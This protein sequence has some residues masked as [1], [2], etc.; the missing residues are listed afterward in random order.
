MRDELS[1]D[2]IHLGE[3]LKKHQDC[4]SLRLSY[5][6]KSEEKTKLAS[7]ISTQNTKLAELKAD[8]SILTNEKQQLQ[9]SVAHYE[10]TREQLGQWN[11]KLTLHQELDNNSRALLQN[12]SKKIT[13]QK[14]LEEMA[15][16]QLQVYEDTSKRV[17][18]LKDANVELEII[19]Q[20]ILQSENTINDCKSLATLL[21]NWNSSN[22]EF[23]AKQQSYLVSSRKSRELSDLFT[24]NNQ[25]FMDE[26]AGILAETLEEGS[27]C[28][29]CGSTHHLAYAKLTENAPT[30]ES[31][32]TMKENSDKALE[33]ANHDM[34]ETKSLQVKKDGLKEQVKVSWNIIFPTLPIETLSYT[35][36]SD[37]LH[38]HQEQ[39]DAAHKDILLKLNKANSDVEE[40]QKL[41][42]LLPALQEGV[43]TNQDNLIA[44]NIEIAQLD[45]ELTNY[46]NQ[47][48]KQWENSEEIC[49]DNLIYILEQIGTLLQTQC[50]N[51]ETT[52]NNLNNSKI[53]LKKIEEELLPANEKS[54]ELSTTLLQ[55]HT[56]EATQITTTLSSLTEQLTK[57][58]D[59]LTYENKD[60]VQV[61]IAAKNALI[62]SLKDAFEA[63][64][65]KYNTEK[66]H[67]TL[68]EGQL[69]SLK[70]TIADMPDIDIPSLD[71][72]VLEKKEEIKTTQGELQALVSQ[73]DSNTRNLQ[74][75][76]A[77]S[78][79]L[80]KVEQKFQ[81]MKSLSDTA[82]GTLTKKERIMLETFIQM[83]YFD[84]VTRRANI[85]LMKMTSGQFELKRREDV[86]SSSGK[87]GL[88][89]DVVDHYN[90]STR[91]VKTLSGGE[92]FKASL[93]LALGLADEIQSNAGGIKLDTMFVDEGFGSLDEESLQQAIKI[94]MELGDGNRLV[95]IISHV[96]ELK[97]KIDKQLIITKN[98][99]EGSSHRIIL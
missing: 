11:T 43:K 12:R 74:H 37:N 10:V 49:E 36:A 20:N 95:G 16:K 1:K 76:Q 75:I 88:D 45:N 41:A 18:E 13:E 38:V 91:S 85:R 59:T 97:E 19:K 28:P 89:L 92:S 4:E 7:S 67:Y 99:S 5:K 84:R 54:Q 15:S 73:L 25:I 31:L 78:V 48:K 72:K 64:E 34:S 66:T 55:N 47:V 30:K 32:K 79:E 96:N 62:S 83:G 3:E 69:S 57:L 61:Q 86:G 51:L 82:N 23:Q 52:L 68:L 42:K 60:Q 63:S 93:A 33:A 44:C 77:K 46:I 6:I 50:N 29:V 9:P 90:G 58:E 17:E 53:R 24:H 65:E 14:Q 26:Q 35:S 80:L 39:L 2:V 40:L 22:Q 21:A 98:A 56:I 70:E 27:P 71:T 81:W 87:K 8:K 94:L